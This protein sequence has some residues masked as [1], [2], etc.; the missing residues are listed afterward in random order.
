MYTLKF[1]K[2]S[3]DF[4]KKLDSSNRTRILNNI[5]K[6]QEDYT[7][8]PFKKLQGEKDKFRIRVGKYRIIYSVNNHELL[9]SVIKI[10][11][12]KNIYD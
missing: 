10:G 12:R 4:L 2:Q 3:L 5:K 7:Q 11:L 1:S 9:I 8:L 6:L